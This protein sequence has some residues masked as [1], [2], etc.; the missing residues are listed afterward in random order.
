M[1]RSGKPNS[2]RAPVIS[3]GV[4]YVG[5][6]MPSVGLEMYVL[7]VFGGFLGPICGA[8]P[9]RF[10]GLPLFRVVGKPFYRDDSTLARWDFFFFLAVGVAG[11]GAM[12]PNVLLNRPVAFMYLRRSLVALLSLSRNLMDLA[13]I[14]N[15]AW[16][17][18]RYRSYAGHIIR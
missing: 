11:A 18:L 5:T 2:Y 7:Y 12:F 14:P 3:G 9:C 10:S 17:S 15:S 1:P 4:V 6:C 8:S 16:I 13:F